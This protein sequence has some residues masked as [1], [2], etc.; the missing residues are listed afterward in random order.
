MN[1]SGKTANSTPWA[2]ARLIAS[3]TRSTVPLPPVRSG[4][5]WTAA[6][7]IRFM[8]LEAEQQAYRYA[9]ATT[10][11]LCILLRNKW[12]TYAHIIAQGENDLVKNV[13]VIKIQTVRMAENRPATR[14]GVLDSFTRF[15][16]RSADRCPDATTRRRCRGEDGLSAQSAGQRA[17]G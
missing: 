12:K 6:A 14:G 4:A 8:V 17:Y 13:L 7:L 10:R 16:R 1:V 15:A 3:Q 9:L 11:S 5:I 2:P